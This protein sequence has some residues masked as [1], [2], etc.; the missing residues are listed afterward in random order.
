MTYYTYYSYETDKGID[1]L[2]YIGYRKLKDADTPQE[3]DYFGTPKSPRNKDFK[4][5]ENKAKIILGEFETEEEAIAHEIYLHELWSVDTNPH[6]ANM[7][8]Q[9]SK[10]FYCSDPWNKG[11]KLP[12]DVWNKGKTGLQSHT[13]E[14]KHE[15]SERS[16]GE[17]NVFYEGKRFNW[18]NKNSGKIE[19]NTTVIELREKYDELKNSKNQL[20]KVTSGTRKSYRGWKLL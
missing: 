18:V 2:G 3:E 6:F 1:G 5:N 17:K 10:K 7:A 16:K 15:A 9:T 13:D 19:I 14:W 11:I 20:Y 12:Y 8:K 4:E